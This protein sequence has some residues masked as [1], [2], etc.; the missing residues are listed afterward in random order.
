M[1]RWEPIAYPGPDN[2]F[3]AATHRNFN[4]GTGARGSWLD[5]GGYQQL[6]DEL[7]A[8]VEAA[9]GTLDGTKSDQVLRAV[10][11]GA[12]NFNVVGGTAN[13]LTVDLIPNLT[14]YSTGLPLRLVMGN[15]PNG[16]AMTISVD[17]LA[18]KPLLRR[19]GEAIEAGDVPASSV[20]D[21]VDV[22][23]AFRCV[24]LLRSDIYALGLGSK[25]PIHAEVKTADGRF[26]LTANAGSVV[27]SGAAILWRGWKEFD[28]A[29]LS[30]GN[31]TLATAAS[32]TYHLR[33]DAP[34]T[35]LA[36]PAVSYPNGRLSLRDLADVAYNPSVLAEDD[37]TF[38]S[39]FDSVLV[40]RV[41]TN[42]ANVATITALANRAALRAAASR[43]P[44]KP[45]SSLSATHST[46]WGRT[47]QIAITDIN[48]PGGNRDTDI[49]I[50]Q[51]QRTR[52]AT[53]M[54]AQGWSDEQSGGAGAPSW[55]YA[56]SL[57]A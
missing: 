44:T 19:G 27:L 37:G 35:G 39:T 31:R 10:R 40:S 8:L 20:L 46:D 5:A 55:G 54:L 52:Y 51:S 11:S 41:V 3:G 17:G 29:A 33:W 28:L 26:T 42:G 6:I 9:G 32:K 49:Q 14:A 16:G 7:C 38:D 25:L 23:A 53:V 12:L 18:A 21:V 15:T 36:T 57:A 30:L 56:I 48:P 22:G 1:K 47:P 2:G 24:E 45:A 43:S 34:G 13:D 4:Q 50:T